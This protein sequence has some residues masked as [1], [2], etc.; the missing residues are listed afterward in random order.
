MFKSLFS[1]R[2]ATMLVLALI[3][4]SCNGDEPFAL[5][6]VNETGGTFGGDVN[7]DGGN[8]QQSYKWNN[9]LT[10]VDWNMDI[11]SLAGGSFNLSI[12]DADGTNVLNQ[13]LVAG[14]GDDS[15]SGVSSA[16]TAGEWT[17]TITL[18]N[19]DGDGSFSIT[20]GN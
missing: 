13:S 6:S 18:A 3:L 9:A 1:F 11:T 14:Q 5:V 17:I 4:F 2:V 10:T 7:G 20:P 16:G 8:T 15:K 19:F 12:T